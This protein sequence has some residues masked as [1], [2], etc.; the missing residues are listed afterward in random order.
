MPHNPLWTIQLFHRYPASGRE[1]YENSLAQ[2]AQNFS[3]FQ[4][5]LRTPFVITHGSTSK[6]GFNLWAKEL[7]HVHRNVWD[8]IGEVTPFRIK[9]TRVFPFV[10]AIFVRWRLEKSVAEKIFIAARKAYRDVDVRSMAITAVGLAVR[11]SGQPVSKKA[12]IYREEDRQW[13]VFPFREEIE[14]GL[15]QSLDQMEEEE[16]EIE[17][18]AESESEERSIESSARVTWKSQKHNWKTTESGLLPD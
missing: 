5:A 17:K 14:E 3:R 18:R 4:I 8:R 9:D 15:P 13:K 11:H 2:I 12:I 1:Y 7:I 10:P 6:V 16:G